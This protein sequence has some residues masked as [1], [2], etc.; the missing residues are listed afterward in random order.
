VATGY[1][2]FDTLVIEPEMNA[3]MRI[4]QA[5][6]AVPTFGKVFPVG[7]LNEANEKLKHLERL[8]VAFISAVFPQEE[9]AAFIKAAK[10]SKIGQDAAY[11]LVLKTQKQESANIAQNVLVGS[12]GLLFEPYSVDSLVEITI[13]AA[14]V[15]GERAQAR[16]EA[17][18]RML[19]RDIVDTVSVIAHLR[20]QKLETG[21]QQKKLKE[22]C[23]I[24]ETLSPN[25]KASYLNIVVDEFEKAPIFIPP[26]NV[27]Q[28]KGVSNRIKKKLEEKIVAQLKKD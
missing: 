26:K 8:D 9:T 17:A 5:T 23:S 25:M 19:M 10:N 14:K 18:I 20:G 2:K 1:E 13:L 3:R 28:Y 22:M 15:K 11:I 27:P 24:F 4:K 6:S 21:R 16:E 12:D 7:S